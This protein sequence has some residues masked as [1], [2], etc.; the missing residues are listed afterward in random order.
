VARPLTW[1]VKND[2]VIRQGGEATTVEEEELAGPTVRHLQQHQG[3]H[4]GMP[5][6]VGEIHHPN[7]NNN[8]SHADPI[9]SDS[10]LNGIDPLV[11]AD[12]QRDLE[13]Q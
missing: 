6:A 11:A 13:M 2:L 3:H 4:C 5:V 12:L 9:V 10:N 1:T 8:S 7:S